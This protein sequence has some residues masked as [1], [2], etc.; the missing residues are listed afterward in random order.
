MITRDEIEAKAAGFAL[1][2]S[3]IERDYVFGWLLTGIFGQSPLKDMLIL[4]GNCFRKAYFPHTRFSNDLDF[5]SL[6][7]VQEDQLIAELNRICGFVQGE[8][9][10]TFETER[11]WVREKANSDKDRRPWPSMRPGV[12]GYSRRMRLSSTTPQPATFS[13]G[14]MYSALVSAS[15]MSGLREYR[16]QF[17]EQVCSILLVQE[18]RFHCLRPPKIASSNLL[19]LRNRHGL[20]S[21]AFCR[22]RC[23]P[24]QVAIHR[25]RSFL[26]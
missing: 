17:S 14:S 26:P 23:Q 10:V 5:S 16:L 12:I 11:N 3:N 8:T 24:V 15:F 19:N 21:F 22:L 9:G 2:P 4:K 7:A 13:A 20:E 18:R 1:H 6:S 25:V